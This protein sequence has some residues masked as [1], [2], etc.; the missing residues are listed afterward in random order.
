M[1]GT[2]P[3]LYRLLI[4]AAL[5]CAA[6]A[7]SVQADAIPAG[8]GSYGDLVGLLDEF[9]AFRDPDGDEPRQIIRDEAGQA[10]D[11]IADYGEESIAWRR[12]QMR[13]FQARI[14][15]P[16]KRWKLSPMDLQ[17]RARWV[18]YSKAKDDMFR[19]TDIK[20]APWYVVNA[21][22]KKRARLNCIRHLLNSIPY[23][24]LPQEKIDLPKRDETNAYDDLKPLAS[25]RYVPETY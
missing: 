22:D 21:E 17:S 19:H 3:A 2:S 4:G 14:D 12:E 11:P 10:I 1:Q 18:E 24:E 7:P 8:T 25:R 13:Q 6:L 5:L 15:D 16:T 9:L 20:Q 23:K